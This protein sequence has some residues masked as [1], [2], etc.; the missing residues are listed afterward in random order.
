MTCIFYL[1][2]LAAILRYTPCLGAT[3]IPK[4]VSSGTYMNIWYDQYIQLMIIA[5]KQPTPN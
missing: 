5:L 3:V 1:L 2:L 4:L